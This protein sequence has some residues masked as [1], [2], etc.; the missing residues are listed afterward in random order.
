MIRKLVAFNLLFSWLSIL[1]VVAQDQLSR[2]RPEILFNKGL[3]LINHSNYGAAREV[4]TELLGLTPHTDSRRPEVEYQVALCALHLGHSDAEKLIEDFIGSYPSNPRAVTAN[5]ELANFFYTG[6]NFSKASLYFAKVEF[7]ALSRDQQAEGRFRW[8]YS[9]FTLKKLDE[10]LAQFN[11]VKVQ[12][13]PYLP[14]ANYYAGFIEYLNGLYDAALMDLRKAENNPAYSPL[15]PVVIANVLYKQQNY[16]DLIAYHKSL[17][18]KASSISNFSEVA[19]LAA[20]AYYF[21]RDYKSAVTAYEDYFEKN[22]GKA[23][24]PVLFRAGYAYYTLGQ[25]D[26]ALQYLKSSAAAPDSVG[27]YA[28]YYLGILY[29]KQGDKQLALNAFDQARRSKSDKALQEESTF[30]LAKVAYDAGKP[31]QSITE[32]EQ[33]LIDFPRSTHTIE[34]KELLAQAYVNGNNYNKAIDYIESLPARSHSV[35]QAY[36][37]ATFLKGSE[38]FN[39]EDY[40]QA[41]EYFQKSLAH[42]INPVYTGLAAYWCGESLST[43]R[44]YNEATAMFQRVVS[45]GV[46]VEPEVLVR[47]RY[48]LGYAHFNQQQ[49][50]QALFNF[51]EFVNK[52]NRS[53]PTYSD[54]V[55]RLAD[56][57]YVSKQ[58]PEALAQYNRAR[59]LDSPDDDYILFQTGV[60]NGILRKYTEARN[61][62]TVLI[63]SYPKSQFRDEAIFQ[64][65]QFEIEQG[66]YQEAADGL[67]QL[68]RE[69]AG[70]RFLPYAYLRRAASYYNL[71][72]YD[73][74]ITDYATL[75]QQ[76]P[77]HPAAQQALIPLQE[78]LGLAGRTGDF[79]R[80]LDEF[81]K[82]N[83]DNKNLE[84]V[85]FE[86]AKNL[87]FDQQYAKA[88][89][90]LQAFLITYPESARIHDV[91]YY[92]AESFYRQRDFDKAYPL[93]EQLSNDLTFA[94]AGRSVGRLAEI[95]FRQGKYDRA[96]INYHRMERL[97]STKKDLYTAWSGLMESFY[98]LAAYDSVTTYANLIIEKGNI[99]AGAVNKASLFIGKAAMARGN[100]DLAKD[101]F[102]NTLNS[103]R[104]E[105]GAEAKYR[106]AEIFFN[107]GQHKSCYETLISLNT[108]FAA[109]D[110]WVGRSYLLLSDNFMAMDD[111]F[112]AK[113]TLESLIGKFPLQHIQDMA[114]DKL[115]K[116]ADAEKAKRLK[117]AAADSVDNK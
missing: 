55:L 4:F 96:I 66:N 65:A 52:G 116:I 1:P 63:S 69:G 47:T 39:K 109:Y 114:N 106:L 61:Q 43:L 25:N 33:F 85:E 84:V 117:Q 20:D 24:A 21:K 5:Y 102:L 99:N 2:G 62:F 112:N 9:L 34:V 107:T 95:D 90:A 44:K 75:L 13:S 29:V 37:K 81:K 115:K 91:K 48:G 94:L 53:F 17:L 70:S 71:K 68:I 89:P 46:S 32:F 86:S 80:Y 103:A 3:E 50:E 12:D 40:T 10:A 108:D 64:R 7:S 14:A 22:A 35:N 8:G 88:I 45:L 92:L 18:P 93:Y 83:P 82:A 49:Y 36:Q 101:E 51:K 11:L 19:L 97:A 23:P 54:G 100:Y 78:A 74:T 110:E 28:S 77:A 113:A 76:F 57:H 38:F 26:R 98:L 60:I 30:Q 104:D 27:H 87:Y 79:Q 42:P 31:D 16:D 73:K 105:Y 67:S 41:I 15:V 59:Q 111:A 58:Y 6:K 72:Q 56:C